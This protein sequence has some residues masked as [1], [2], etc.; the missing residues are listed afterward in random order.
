M[1]PSFELIKHER[2]HQDHQ[3][4]QWRNGGH[5]RG[6]LLEFDFSLHLST[7]G[8][9]NLMPEMTWSQLSN[10]CKNSAYLLV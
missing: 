9:F 5:F 3:G 2:L 6:A 8:N 7:L 1:M 4:K 10:A